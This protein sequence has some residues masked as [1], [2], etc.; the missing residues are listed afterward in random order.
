VDTILAP[1]TAP[2]GGL[3]S[4]VRLSGPRALDLARGRDGALLL[5]GPRT[6]TRED[7]AE[8]HLP[9]SPPLVRALVDELAALG[10]RPARPGE[11]TLRAFLNGRLDLVRAEAVERLVAAEGEAERRAA[12]D[13]LG[14]AFSRR[15][16]RLESDLLDLCADLEASIDF[17]DQDVEILPAAEARERARR[18]LRDLERLRAEAATEGGGAERPLVV[19]YGEPNAGKSTLF[20]ALAGA[21]AIVSDSPGTT[22]DALE[23]ELDLDGPVR[24]VDTAGDRE[25]AGVEAE[26]VRRSRALLE[27]ADLVLL[28][29]PP[30]G[31]AGLRERIPAGIPVLELATKADLDPVPDASA[32]GLR[33]SA[34]RGEGLEALRG[35]L[36]R[37]LR[38]SRGPGARFQL[39]SRQRALLGEAGAALERALGGEIPGPEFMSADLRGAAAA[40]GGLSGRDV[41]DALLDRIF[42][43]F[44]LGK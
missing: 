4:V 16:G 6:Y 3:R 43:R 23:A 38:G 18:L 25:S 13:L 7:M 10:A 36:A 42:G 8:I 2:G 20:N 40:L 12:L 1:A 5:P 24:L 30:G 19:L 33:V 32:R 41:D 11:F 34:R 37:R 14:G 26:A 31:G 15:L 28:C 22:R 44:C 9:G 21:S 17:V 27:G 29:T 39:S 35:E